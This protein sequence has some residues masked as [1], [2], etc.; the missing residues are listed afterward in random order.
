MSSPTVDRRK[1]A[2]PPEREIPN[3]TTHIFQSVA[4]PHVRGNNV[5]HCVEDPQVREMQDT[6][7]R[8]S[9]RKKV[10]DPS[11]TE[12]LNTTDP[13]FSQCGG[14]TYEGNLSYE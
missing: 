8:V 14:P 7:S 1:V 12:I 5:I 9:Y 2:D 10:E 11:E 13:H 4:D 6:N 3:V